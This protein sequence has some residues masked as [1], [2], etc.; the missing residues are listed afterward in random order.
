MFWNC[1]AYK[2]DIEVE[3]PKTTKNWGIGCIGPRQ[4]SGG[5][6]ESWG[7]HVLPRS[8]YLQQL[9]DRLGAQALQNIVTPDQ[10]QGR[11]WDSL[12][13][14]GTRIAQEPKVPYG[15]PEPGASFDIT[16]NG[17]QIAAQYPNT[18]KPSEDVPSIIDNST[19]TKYYRSGRTNLWVQY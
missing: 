16:D 5:Y 12:K 2:G 7:T 9:Q 17:G 19:T 14:R 8:L 13:A 15:V 18:T 3:S 4:T 6:W 11:I 10:A 1:F